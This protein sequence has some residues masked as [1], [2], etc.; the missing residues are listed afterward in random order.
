MMKI[1]ILTHYNVSSHG[2]L[3]QMY[4]LQEVLKSMGHEVFILTYARNLDFIDEETKKRFSASIRNI[5][6]YISSYMGSDGIGC[7]LYQQKKQKVL[8]G[9]RSQNFRMMPYVESNQLD[10]VV[11]GAD[12][13][14]SLENGI[15][16]MMF[17]HCVTSGRIIAYAPSSGQT[18]L[19]RIDRYGCREL[20]QSGLKRFH[21]L[22]AR[23]EGT[24]RM[25]DALTGSDVPLVCDPALLHPFAHPVKQA[26][27][28]YIVV[29][30]YQSNFKDKDRIAKIREYARKHDC[31]LWSVGV[32]YRWCDRQINC[33]PLEMI[34]IFANAEAVITDTFH[35]TIASYIAHTPMAVFIRENNCVKLDHLLGLI[36]I[37]DRKA[38]SPDE[39][40]GVLSRPVNFSALDG[41]VNRLRQAGRAYLEAALS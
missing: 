36:G 30:S 21:A 24:K 40:D 27:K 14:F 9:F 17:G 20:I 19:G 26:T 25:V 31:E 1:G 28:K 32:Y 22:S 23:D 3:L 35:G 37:G 18:D 13:V 4:A 12:E 33:D 34:R 11:V 16:M 5:P 41:N 39:L 29:Y 8:G 6:Y 2:A 10:C 15:N 7:L 38:V